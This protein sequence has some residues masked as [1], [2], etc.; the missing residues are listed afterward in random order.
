MERRSRQGKEKK[1]K[2][3][4]RRWGTIHPATDARRQS[5]SRVDAL[6]DEDQGFGKEDDNVP[7]MVD[8][9]LHLGAAGKDV[10]SIGAHKRG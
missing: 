9:M 1:R 4:G 2:K 8:E 5:Q 6:H 3:K 7:E 10:V